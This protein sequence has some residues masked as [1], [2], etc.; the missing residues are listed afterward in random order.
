M[1]SY[2]VDPE[3]TVVHHLTVIEVG[4]PTYKALTDAQLAVIVA[5]LDC[6]VVA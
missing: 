5:M 2:I 4:D 1:N 3:G 6:E